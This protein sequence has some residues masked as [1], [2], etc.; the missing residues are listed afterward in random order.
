MKPGIRE[1]SGVLLLL[2]SLATLCYAVVLLRT[3]DYL[4]CMILVLTGLA[5]LRAAVELLRPS[6]GE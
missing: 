2:S 5:L 3:R 1:A 4:A 6:I